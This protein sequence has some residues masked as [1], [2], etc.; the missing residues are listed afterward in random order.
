MIPRSRVDVVHDDEPVGR[1]RALMAVGHSRYPVVDQHGD[2]IGVVHM[3]DLLTRDVPDDELATDL[4][5]EALVVPT[6]MA[7]PDALRELSSSDNEMACV[8]DEYGGFAGVLT[9]EDLAE[10]LVGEITDEHDEEE[11]P[12]PDAGDDGVWVMAGDIHLDEVERAI[13]HDL[14]EGDWETIAGLVIAENGALPDVG[15]V[16]EVDLPIDPADL[17]NPEPPPITVMKVEITEI[18]RHVPSQVRVSLDERE[19]DS[20]EREA[21]R[22][23]V[24]GTQDG[25]ADPAED[26]GGDGPKAR[27]ETQR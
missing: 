11:A 24:H 14:P 3:T 15:D 6:T 17:A 27:A 18:E 7:L 9:L 16:V 23:L 22:R 13:D 20:D 21:A 2:V 19:A 4:Q 25:A 26:D 10:E 1:I 12:V 8:I 5:R